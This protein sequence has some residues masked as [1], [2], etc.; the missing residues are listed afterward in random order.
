MFTP[1]AGGFYAGEVLTG[2]DDVCIQQNLQPVVIQTAFGWQASTM[3]AGPAA[4]YYRMVR[5]LR[6]GILSITATS[7]PEELAILSHIDEP[8]VAIAGRS[9]H[10][11][12]PSMVVDNA[13]GAALAVEHFLAHGHRRIGF[14]G[15]L[16]QDDYVGRYRGYC[17]A[18]EAAGIDVDPALVRIA[19]TEMPPS[20]RDAAKSLLEAGVPPSAIFAATDGL[21]LDL[22]MG[23]SQAGIAVPD[24]IAVIGFND[25]E[26]AQSAVPAL[27]SVRQNPR[28][29]GAAAMRV[30]LDLMNGTPGTEGA[31]VMSTALVLRHSCG[32][33]DAEEGLV[34]SAHDW[35]A[36][37]WK[38][39]L[40]EVLEKALV[41]LPELSSTDHSG[42]IW[43]GVKTVIRAFDAAVLGAPAAHITELDEAWRS[44]SRQTR[45]AETLLGLVDLL[46][47]VGLCRQ[48][49]A[50]KDPDTIR[51]R[52]RE[53]LAQARLQILRYCA[54]VDSVHTEVAD[55]QLDLTRWF[56]S[57]EPGRETD[58]EWLSKAN[59]T[60][61][62]LAFWEPTEHGRELVVRATYGLA[63]GKLRA[64]SRIAVE[65]FPPADWVGDAEADGASGT[66]TIL[67]IGTPRHDWGVL[68]ALLNKEHR[69]F[70]DFWALQHGCS[71]L[72]LVLERDA[73]SQ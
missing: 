26:V 60:H 64:G 2:I 47:F 22:M 14:V 29:L 59:A 44:A 51:P 9:P 73:A 33:F 15:A 31:H 53:F 71:L 55:V 38:E 54:T 34:H 56:L 4:D 58:L 35:N 66:V 8:M 5:A 19:R 45:N 63:S 3:D 61:G 6:I 40:S 49:G 10:P 48:P 52:L 24:E 42:E 68:A 25:S 13:G 62:C 27:T 65:D 67:P 72:A 69:Y 70:D 16:N 57:L 39:R 1:Q 43:P 7:H 50:S 32:C 12:G 46:E 30:L 21:A 41:G 20:G 36:P 28:A 18:L 17:S 23:F 11:D 37:D